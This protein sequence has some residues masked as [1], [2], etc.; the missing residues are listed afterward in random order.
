MAD[1]HTIGAEGFEVTV[2]AET[3]NLQF[4]LPDAAQ[5]GAGERANQQ[6]QVAAHTRRQ[7]HGDAT[8]VQ[9]SGHQRDVIVDPGA[10]KRNVIPGKPFVME[11]LN[12]QGDV[13]GEVRQMSYVGTLT[14]LVAAFDGAA[15]VPC[16]LR[17][18]AGVPYLIAAAEGGG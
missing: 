11:Q 7:Y 2:W 9:V 15:A 8:V 4:F 6:R 13:E 17:S 14:N 18:P 5:D 1:P 10:R 16:Q 12:A 3:A